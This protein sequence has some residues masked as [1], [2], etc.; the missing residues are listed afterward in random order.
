MVLDDG[1]DAFVSLVS[2]LLNKQYVLYNIIVYRG[3][4]IL[5]HFGAL[6]VK[7]STP[8]RSTK[9]TTDTET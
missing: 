4:I 5:A 9:P 1:V 7:S 2:L 6:S 3:P 8:S